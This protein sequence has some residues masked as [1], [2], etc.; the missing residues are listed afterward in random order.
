[1]G[2]LTIAGLHALVAYTGHE[3]IWTFVALQAAMMFC[4]GLMGA[5]FNA[6]AMEPLGHVA[7]TASSIQGF[8]TTTF[9][10]LLGFAV[11][12]QFDGSTV[13]LT[14][15]FFGLGLITLTAILITERGRLFQPNPVH[16]AAAAAK[17]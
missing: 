7:G 5:N 2:Y 3:N 14:V 9:G 17:H 16:A 15:D 4:F 11:G 1:M 8:V 12:Q 10:A 13:P 6:L